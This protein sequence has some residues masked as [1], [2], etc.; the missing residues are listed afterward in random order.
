MRRSA[1]K[2][3]DNL[4]KKAEEALNLANCIENAVARFSEK[5][6]VMENRL[7]DSG[8]AFLVVGDGEEAI[9]DGY[10]AHFE[11]LGYRVRW[12]GNS[13]LHVDLPE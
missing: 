12:S 5:C 9:V 2:S 7:A 4:R 10:V 3:I 1:Q 11:R 6:A 8:Y 13:P